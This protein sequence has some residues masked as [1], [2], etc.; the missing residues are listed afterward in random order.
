MP[1]STRICSWD[2]LSRKDD[3][4]PAAKRQS[5]RGTAFVDANFDK[6]A[7][8][9]ISDCLSSRAASVGIYKFL[10][11]MRA[12]AKQKIAVFMRACRNMLR[13]KSRNE[14][15]ETVHAQDDTL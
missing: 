7:G 4:R 9:D 8:T 2:L 3:R 5:A 6:A 12:H 1:S 15:S 13:T 14:I 11:F 10:H